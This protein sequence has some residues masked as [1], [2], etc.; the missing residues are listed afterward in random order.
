MDK[1][2]LDF[3]NWTVVEY[4]TFR[5]ATLTGDS[6]KA[7]ELLAKVITGWDNPD[8]DPHDSETYKTLSLRDIGRVIK[9]VNELGNQML[10]SA[11]PGDGFEVDVTGWNYKQFTD[12]GKAVSESNYSKM[13]DL[14]QKIIRKWPFKE[15]LSKAALENINFEYYCRLNSA[16]A[17]AV[18]EAM[19]GE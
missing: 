3:E 13:F 11:E 19:Q 4:E 17:I 6:D 1:I 8:L 7:S 9:T 5:L 12:Y 15:E 16:V 18:K 14:L 10:Q 2:L